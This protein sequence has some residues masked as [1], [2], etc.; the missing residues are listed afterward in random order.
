MSI[1]PGRPAGIRAKE[2]YFTLGMLQ[3]GSTALFTLAPADDVGLDD[4]CSAQIRLDRIYRESQLLCY[5]SSAKTLRTQFV[6]TLFLDLGHGFRLL[7][8]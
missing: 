6:D 1:P 5:P 4:R 7:Y 8:R 3:N 2:L